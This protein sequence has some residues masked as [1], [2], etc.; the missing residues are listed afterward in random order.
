MLGM[1]T[2]METKNPHEGSLVGVVLWGL[3]PL[4]TGGVGLSPPEHIF[5]PFRK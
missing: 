1:V 4:G 3:D 2:P 5:L